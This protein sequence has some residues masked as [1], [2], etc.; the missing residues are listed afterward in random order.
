MVRTAGFW[1]ALAFGAILNAGREH[2]PSPDGTPL[3]TRFAVRCAGGDPSRPE[4]R[5]APSTSPLLPGALVA[6]SLPEQ[7]L[8][9]AL[10]K[11]GASLPGHGSR[12]N[13]PTVPARYFCMLK[14]HLF[15]PVLPPP[16]SSSSTVASTSTV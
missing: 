5:C 9:G 12:P 14:V 13:Q 10:K 2:I 16:S 1:R 7:D 6:T 8:G 15:L 4:Q 11:E 3:S